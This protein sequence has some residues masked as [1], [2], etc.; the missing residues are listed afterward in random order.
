MTEPVALPLPR[1]INLS[2]RQRQ[3]LGLLAAGM[4]NEIPD[5][6]AS[7]L[8]PRSAPLRSSALAVLRPSRLLSTLVPRWPPGLSAISISMA[9]WPLCSTPKTYSTPQPRMIQTGLFQPPGGTG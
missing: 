3:V 9:P 5:R 6:D 8:I 2:R 7:S 1:S 4:T